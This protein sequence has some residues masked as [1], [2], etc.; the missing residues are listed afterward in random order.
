MAENPQESS[1]QGAEHAHLPPAAPPRN[2][3]HTVAAWVTVSIVMLGGVVASAAVVASLTWLFWV[4]LGIV[5][6]GVVVGLVLRRAGLGQPEPSGP[7]RGGAGD[8]V[9]RG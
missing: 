8:D 5:V 7:R 2:H 6:L 9:P 1:T 4:G 3:G